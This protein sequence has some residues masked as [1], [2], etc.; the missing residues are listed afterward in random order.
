MAPFWVKKAPPVVE[1][2][3]PEPLG[4]PY[5]EVFT[6]PI[7]LVVT[8]AMTAIF[9]VLRKLFG[10]PKSMFASNPPIAA[11]AFTFM[12]PFVY[13][14]IRGLNIWYFDDS[15]HRIDRRFGDHSG[16]RHLIAVMIGTQIFDIP[17]SILI[18]GP[19][20][21]PN[22]VVH[23]VV[24]LSLAIL[25]L[26]YRF[27]FYY[28]VYFMGVTELSTPLLAFVDLFRDF[29]KFALKFPNT[30]ET[31]RIS[32][33]IAFFWVRII[34]WLPISVKFWS[35]AFGMLADTLP[36]NAL[37][38]GVLYLWL[39]VHTFLTILQHW[40]IKI[41][42]AAYL[43]AIGDKSAREIEAKGA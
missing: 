5:A 19:L 29:P 22:F 13:L 3:N 4:I 2:I 42:K 11:H 8:I 7:V 33:A 23:H 32:F 27:A 37:P 40:G 9:L 41:A 36:R 15:L 17:S 38:K 18:G 26:R 25:A 21:A 14:A 28:G 35:D 43:M 1:T 24:V 16:G 31:V 20:A 12:L 6:D 10:H 30:N 39:V 34:S